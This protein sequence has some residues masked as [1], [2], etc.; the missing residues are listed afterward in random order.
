MVDIGT[1]SNERSD[2]APAL[3]S[4]RARIWTVVVACMGV[5]LVISSMVAF[6][7]ALG[8]IAI[9]TS[10]TQSQLTWVVDGY[11]VVLA[12]LLLPAGAIGDRYGRRGALL[13]GLATF[14]IASAVGAVVSGPWQIIVTRGV[15]GAGAAFIMP[16]TL[17]LLTA[18]YR[19]DERMKAVGIWAGVAGCGGVIGMLGSG[20]LLHF[21][22]WQSIFWAFAGGATLIFVLACTVSSSRDER[23]IPLDW[24]GAVLIGG[25]VA[26]FVFGVVEAPERGWTDPLVYT[27]LGAGTLLAVGFGVVEV[28]RRYPLLDVRLFGRPDFATG[29]ATITTFFI[30]M[31]GFFFVMMQFMQLVM[32]YSP[33]QTALAF[34]P[35][36]VPMLT[37]SLLS[38]WYLPRLGLRLVT[39][40]GLL[41]ISAGFVWLRVLEVDSPYWDMMWPLLVVSTGIGFCTAPSTSAIMAAV[42]DEKQGVASAVNDTTREVGA[43]LGIALAGSILA[44]RYGQVLG[45]QLADFPEPIRGPASNSLAQALNIA[46]H[47]GPQGTQLAD[48]SRAAFLQAME[49]SVLVLAIIIAVA[50]ALIG[51]WA[52][53]PDGRQLRWV[54]QFR[55][56][57]RNSVDELCRTVAEHDDRG[58]RSAA[59][60]HREY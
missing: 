21:W 10:A 41:L 28:K 26:V 47:L 44:A 23:A 3:G 6:N 15:A 45:G 60:D 59:G 17:S 13:F 36:M 22:P 18:A 55:S 1:Q 49:S 54:R 56:R 16:A 58:V 31:F 2:A 24:P 20:T 46:K 48:I 42:P 51:A 37:L 9:A 38:Q 7:T 50:A 8:D 43:A 29:A 57:R 11:T 4:Q 14:A 27:T 12:C 35:L 32:G 25:A 40:T 5:S 33:M 34:S 19:N 39:F 53:G 30:A 52:P